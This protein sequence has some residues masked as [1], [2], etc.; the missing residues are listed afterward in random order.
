[1]EISETVQ[2]NESIERRECRHHDGT[3]VLE[4]LEAGVISVDGKFIYRVQD[5][6]LCMLPGDAIVQ[7]SDYFS[8]EGEI[9]THDSRQE[10]QEF[11]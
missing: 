4:R 3:T 10:V 5:Y 8:H 11:L 6:I 7:P 2:L 9:R 1:M